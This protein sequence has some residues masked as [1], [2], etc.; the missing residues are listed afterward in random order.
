MTDTQ[1]WLARPVPEPETPLRV[2]RQWVID[3]AWEVGTGVI[4]PCCQNN[5]KVYHRHIN[6]GMARSAIT[7][8]RL[9][10]AG[11]AWV[12]V[13]RQVG[14]TSREEGKLA[15]WGLITEDPVRHSGFW[16]LTPKGEL[17]VLNRITV[18]Y[19]ALV[20]NNRLL[21]LD[22]KPWSVRDALGE[23]FSYEALMGNE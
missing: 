7:I 20:Y 22:G 3:G 18:P 16:Q 12:N 15:Y 11:D 9:H 5:C 13:P 2:V 6:A 10:R 17:W 14:A 1:P 19:T 23:R 21:G 8:F 4:C